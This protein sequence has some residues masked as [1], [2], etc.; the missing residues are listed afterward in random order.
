[1]SDS[2][3][4]PAGA[5]V[6]ESFLRCA[7][8]FVPMLN[9][10]EVRAAWDKPSAL[11]ELSTGGLAFHLGRQVQRVVT[12]LDEPPPGV[13]AGPVLDFAGY[14]TRYASKAPSIDDPVSVLIRDSCHVGA[15]AGAD[16][17]VE[18]TQIALEWLDG[19]LAREDPFRLVALFGDVLPL[20][21]A[22][23]TRLVEVV[24]HADDL[25]A[26]VG[27]PSPA[28]DDETG[29]LVV[30]ALACLARRRRGT[31]AVVRNLARFER[32]EGLTTAF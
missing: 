21:E 4:R 11:A 23:L 10:A 19:R 8:E 20:D 17:S 6:L 9:S 12:L 25:A 28:F 22:V 30:G 3:Q 31:W 24:I 26:S 13:G 27:L 29:D 2:G 1:M 7:H 14:Y 18:M 32:P 16:S 15:E 5:A